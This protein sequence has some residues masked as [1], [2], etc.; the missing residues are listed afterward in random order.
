M[1]SNC[2]FFVIYYVFSF[3]FFYCLCDS[4][5]IAKAIDTFYRPYVRIQEDNLTITGIVSLAYSVS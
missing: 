1:L 5:V 4:K 2:L 3:F